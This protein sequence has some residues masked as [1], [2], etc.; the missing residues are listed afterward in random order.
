M[1]SMMNQLETFHSQAS[2]IA[3]QLTAADSNLTNII[4][5]SSDGDAGSILQLLKVRKMLVK[6]NASKFSQDAN[7]LIKF[8]SSWLESHYHQTVSLVEN[9]LQYSVKDMVVISTMRICHLTT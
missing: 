2:V 9:T 1:E 4:M 7:I 5:Q 3:S 6:K 8:V